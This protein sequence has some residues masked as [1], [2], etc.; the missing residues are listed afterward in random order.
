VL[1]AVPLASTLEPDEVYALDT[2]IDGVL[3]AYANFDDD[4]VWISSIDPVPR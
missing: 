4:E 2:S 3:M 1:T